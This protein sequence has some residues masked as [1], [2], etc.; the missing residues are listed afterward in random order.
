M[1]NYRR[2]TISDIL[3]SKELR[4]SLR[5]DYFNYKQ[6]TIDANCDIDVRFA[7]SDITYKIMKTRRWEMTIDSLVDYSQSKSYSKDS[8]TDE[9]VDALLEAVPE[10]SSYF[11][12]RNTAEEVEQEAEQ[13]KRRRK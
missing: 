5:E 3:A 7:F 10:Y 4:E 13:P 2:L 12:E 11:I 9:E 1:L 6:I 8:V